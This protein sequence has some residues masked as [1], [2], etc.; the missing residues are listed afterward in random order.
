MDQL[1]EMQRHGIVAFPDGIQKYGVITQPSA[2][3]FKLN[4]PVRTRTY[5]NL[6]QKARDDQTIFDLARDRE[7][8]EILSADWSVK[9]SLD[10]FVMMDVIS[11]K[12]FAHGPDGELDCSCRNGHICLMCGHMAVWYFLQG[13]TIIPESCTGKS[14]RE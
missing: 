10:V 5:A 9:R 11:V 4:D 3:W 13:K 14:S 7:S 1:L 6:G 8:M 2:R 12:D